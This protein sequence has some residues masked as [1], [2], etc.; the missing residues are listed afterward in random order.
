MIL[1]VERC[2]NRKAHTDADRSNAVGPPRTV[3]DNDAA[4]CLAGHDDALHGDNRALLRNLDKT[5]NRPVMIY[6]AAR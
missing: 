6:T 1:F 2:Q 4:G 3:R 5:T